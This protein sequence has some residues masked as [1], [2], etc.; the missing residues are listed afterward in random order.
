[1]K[2]ISLKLIGEKLEQD[3]MSITGS[4][5]LTLKYSG[6]QLYDQIGETDPGIIYV[7]EKAPDISLTDA[8]G[9]GYI[10]IGEDNGLPC[11][12]QRSEYLEI[13]GHSSFATL[14]N[15]IMKTYND[16]QE[17]IENFIYLIST[18]AGLQALIEALY[19]VFGNPCYL[20]DANFKVL[21]IDASHDARYVSATWKHLEDDRYMPLDLVSGLVGSMVLQGMETGNES[22]IISTSFFYVPFI[23]YN[24]RSSGKIQGHL[25]VAELYKHITAGDL[26]MAD[27]LGS[28]LNEH[29]SR[30]EYF[31]RK[32]GLIYE[33]FMKDLFGGKPMERSWIR[34]QLN[35]LDLKKDSSYV[36]AKILTPE[37][38]MAGERI[39][40]VLERTQDVRIVRYDGFIMCLFQLK[41]RS[42]IPALNKQL[43][44]IA[45]AW[46][47]SIG[48]SDCFH[49]VYESAVFASQADRALESAKNEL[50]NTVYNYDAISLSDLI[51][52]LGPR[53]HIFIAPEIREMQSYDE[54][55]H[56]EYIETLKAYLRTERGL[57]ETAALLNIH[58]NTLSYRIEKMTE[59]FSLRLEIPESRYRYYLSILMLEASSQVPP[60]HHPPMDSPSNSPGDLK[61]LRL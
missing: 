29:I 15:R 26:E 16:I 52:H 30:N 12:L 10:L 59:R 25:F 45:Q 51:K 36:V 31:Q 28:I 23:N 58:R 42:R 6:I 35:Y 8:E 55:H 17:Q 40:S 22:R 11:S 24:L 46:K 9:I 32:R 33:N 56:S 7:C 50:Q 37:K 54:N 19:P 43:Y 39:A 60:V 20:V 14:Y 48:L 27:I 34:A 2:E 18:N 49:D 53:E 38:E 47:C 41:N 57:Q 5:A 4:E 3:G 61:A 21:A 1:M 13:S 44:E